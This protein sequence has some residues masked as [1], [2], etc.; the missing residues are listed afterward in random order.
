IVMEY[1]GAGSVSDI[2]RLCRTVM[3]EQQI[4]CICHY[5]LKGLAYLH[6][7]R[8]IHR[9][10]KAG[11]I[12][13]NTQGQAK[14]ADF[15]VA[16]Q[17]TDSVTKRN[18][19]IGTP[20][21]MAPEVIQEVGYGVNADIWSLG[22][23]CIEMA[24][25]R[26]PY[27]NIHPMR[28]IFMIPTKP[29]PKLENEGRFSKTFQ[30]FISR[31]LTKD[32]AKRPSAAELLNDPFVVA[33]EG[34]SIMMDVVIEALDLIAQGG[35]RSSDE[36]SSI[37]TFNQSDGDDDATIKN[38]FSQQ[39]R[40]AFPAA[41]VSSSDATVRP[42]SRSRSRLRGAAGPGDPGG[43]SD[44]SEDFNTM[45]SVGRPVGGV[46]AGGTAMESTGPS[47]SGSNSNSG[48]MIFNGSIAS[49]S[50]GGVPDEPAFIKYFNQNN[51][52]NNNMGFASDEVESRTMK[53]VP[54]ASGSL[55]R[56]GSPGPGI[57]GEP[58][59]R[60]P[61]G[62]SVPVPGS[63]SPPSGPGPGGQ[64]GD[65]ALSVSRIV[66]QHKGQ[67]PRM[68]PRYTPQQQQQQQLQQQQPQ[69]PHRGAS[70]TANVTLPTSSSTTS[71]SSLSSSNSASP[72]GSST[73]L[74]NNKIPPPHSNF[75][76][77]PPPP[78][79]SIPN[80]S[81]SLQRGTPGPASSTSTPPPS[82]FS[83]ATP[84]SSDDIIR[85]T[86]TVD[87]LQELLAALDRNME[88]ELA[89]TRAKFEKRRAPVLEAIAGKK[90]AGSGVQGQQDN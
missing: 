62:P 83:S 25:G 43:S 55:G 77:I 19:V 89:A 59:A 71:L 74:A 90:G 32:P 10:I 67:S 57:S 11:N 6:A 52:S 72:A 2:M 64:K 45:K 35:L 26:P 30:N 47:G 46:G 9:D 80:S 56:M 16:G 42:R 15:G 82:S 21:W 54:S 8:K 68:Q 75:V 33:A 31:C 41:S 22:I 28:A 27:H 5:V 88:R 76:H 58:G 39:P 29:A 38:R 13:L 81:S 3:S 40:R 73:S 24:E 23:T 50:N 7:R 18:T 79:S 49:G 86:T 36:A 17:L 84:S 48:T 14:L 12:L 60:R 37:S 66:Q 63:A 1:C 85:N 51:N 44:D 87:E 20:F 78:S 4:A 34:L 61:S 70:A 65:G 53:P 69:Y